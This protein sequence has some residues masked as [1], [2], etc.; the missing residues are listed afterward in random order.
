M[1]QPAVEALFQILPVVASR[2]AGALSGGDGSCRGRLQHRPAGLRLRAGALHPRPNAADRCRRARQRLLD[3][4]PGHAPAWGIQLAGRVKQMRRHAMVLILA[5]TS[6][7]RRGLRSRARWRRP[8]PPL[9]VADRQRRA[10]LV[11]SHGFGHQPP[12]A[13]TRLHPFE[14]RK[15]AADR[16]VRDVQRD[17]PRSRAPTARLPRP[18]SAAPICGIA[19]VIN[20]PATECT[21]PPDQHA[22]L[23]LNLPADGEH[24]DIPAVNITMFPNLSIPIT[25]ITVVPTA[26][27]ATVCAVA[28]SGPIKQ[29]VTASLP[30]DAQVFGASCVLTATVPVRVEIYG[31]LSDFTI[32]G[33][34]LPFVIPPLQ[35][36]PSCTSNLTSVA[37]KLLGLPLAQPANEI[38]ITGTGLAYQ[39]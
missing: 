15:P 35:P 33:T 9:Q 32:S 7:L 37:D 38:T 16:G 2:A 22:S 12:T 5:P 3:Q 6:G 24:I 25:H 21:S 23:H 29:T 28:A 13:P 14:H 30:A 10:H 4:E 27:T 26:I 8:S 17:Q 31:P 18:L 39:P 36:S 11:A 34:N 1:Y 19:T 20:R